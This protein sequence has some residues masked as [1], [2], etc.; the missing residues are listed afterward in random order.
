[1]K[2][3]RQNLEKP[4]LSFYDCLETEKFNYEE[5]RENAI[6]RL[7]VLKKFENNIKDASLLQSLKED[8]DSHFCLKLICAQS[9]WSANWFVTQETRLFRYR[10]MQNQQET[11]HFLADKV[12]P[13]LN[14]TKDIESSTFYD[15]KVNNKKVFNQEIKVHFT[16]CS[17]I[18]A[19]RTE[20]M[21]FGY[22]K[23]EED[24]LISFLTEIFRAWLEKQMNDLYE[25]GVLESDERLTKLNETI[26]SL[27][28]SNKE[29]ANIDDILS[30]IEY[31]P[32]CIKGLLAKLNTQKHLKYNDRQTLCLFLKDIG[33]ELNECIEFFRKSFNCT[34]E[35]FNKQYLYNIRHNYGL[36]GKRANYHSFTCSKIIGSSND[37][38]S[39]GCPFI[40]NH[41]F[42]RINCDIE[43]LSKD[44]LKCCGKVGEKIL[45][46]TLEM[47]FYSPADYFRIL[48]KESSNKEAC[49]EQ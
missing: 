6:L 44:A 39:F 8:Y 10:A 20:E 34:L 23:L 1:M 47:K 29:N 3:L 38:S 43:D 33:M 45:G 13:H 46:K 40:N 22:F 31:F 19:K 17:E 28:A 18:M 48:H 37:G 16:K 32:L 35:Q 21:V 12:W 26:F 41:E 14:V 2:R 25:K 11:R 24:V 9:K 49:T 27:E 36:E 42:V 30:K 4:E 15:P 7:K 5:F